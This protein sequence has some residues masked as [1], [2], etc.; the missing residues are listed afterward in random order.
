MTES[1]EEQIKQ[2]RLEAIEAQKVL[3]IANHELQLL[4]FDQQIAAIESG[5]AS[6]MPNL[7]VFPH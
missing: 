5:E 7:P 3:A 6:Q 2:K 4:N 1:L